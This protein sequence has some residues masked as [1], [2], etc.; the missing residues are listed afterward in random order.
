MQ[1]NPWKN[2]F[3]QAV[4][5]LQKEFKKTTEIGKKMIDATQSNSELH[6]KFEELGHLALN[7]IKSGELK[8]DNEK[9]HDIMMEIEDLQKALE[10]IEKDVQD[11]KSQN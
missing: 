11:I 4:D 1:N 9:V 8:W 6:A 7:A 10:S 3:N 2:K 5:V